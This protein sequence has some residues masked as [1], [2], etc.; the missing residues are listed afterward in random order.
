MSMPASPSEP[1]YDNVTSLFGEG[2]DDAP[3]PEDGDRWDTPIPL[4]QARALPPFPVDALPG[5]L[6]E[7]VAA[8][9]EETQTPPD[10]AGSLALAVLATAA[11]GRAE[12]LVRGRWREPLNLY[13]VVA[14]PPGNR[15]SA[16]F[17]FMAAPLLAVEKVM[18]E[19]AS[20]QRAEAETMAKLARSAA[21]KASSRAASAAPDEKDALTAEAIALA[22]AAEAATIPEKPQLVID[23][24]TPE[25]AA[26]ML[27]Q[28]GGRIAALSAEGGLFDIIAGR[29]SGTPNMDVFLKAH[30]GDMIR[31]NRQGR[32]SQYIQ[33]PALTIGLAVQPSVLE[34]IAKVRGFEG[35][36]LLARF[37][38]AL[39]KSLVGRRNLEPRTIPDQVAD[40]Y[41]TTLSGLT[42]ALSDWTDPAVLT[43]TPDADRAVLDQQKRTE[44]KLDKGGSLAHVVTWASKLDGAVVRIAGLLH[45]AAHPADGYTRPIEA[46][47]VQ[48]AARIG[49]Y[50]TAHALAVFDAMG[51]DP[52]LGRARTL[53]AHLQNLGAEAVTKRELFRGL[54]RGDFPTVA[55][56]DPA[57]AL[58][59][60]HGWIRQDP[61]PARTGR[62][63]RPP[64]PR[65]QLHP[66]I[67]HPNP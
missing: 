38:Y 16:V 28:Q 45:L 22:Q 5:W 44:P 20:A 3:P 11:G 12:V 29:Y 43:L 59:E 15:K 23:D 18:V 40:T 26:T 33:S 14:L 46:T 2:W 30:A 31:V 61:P 1:P 67:S 49:D 10:L 56:L 9:A 27:D 42:L 37:L 8:V 6:G 50:Y 13:T 34:D 19:A 64:S 51:S 35:R 41:T 52:A 53:L 21:E 55:D 63:G 25:N 17:A 60:E 54:A 39:P 32:E 7:A 48:A 24:I 58:L 57:L 65:F 62:G 47:T 36:G 4:G 66:E